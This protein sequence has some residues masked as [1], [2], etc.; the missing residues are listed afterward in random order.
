MAND[1]NRRAM[2]FH[3]L[4]VHAH[5]AAATRHDKGDHMTGH[6]YSKRA[7][8]HSSKAFQFSKKALANSKKLAQK[9][10]RGK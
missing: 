7:M 9:K 8:E 6:E 2:E 1:A 4:A 10:G 5:Q 3:N